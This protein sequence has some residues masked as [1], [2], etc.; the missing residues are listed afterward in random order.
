MIALSHELQIQRPVREVFDFVVNVE[1]APKWQP[2]VIETRRLTE[3]PI[4]VGTRFQEVARLMGRRVTTICEITE[5]EPS[6]HVS[7]AATSSGPFSY[8]TRYAFEDTEG[9]TRLTIEGTFTLKGFWRLLEPLM[10]SEV[11]KESAHEL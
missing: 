3:G 5:L 10:K 6:Q 7:F 11:R 9:G 8:A 4:R 2:A 1:N